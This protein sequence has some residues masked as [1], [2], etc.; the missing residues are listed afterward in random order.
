MIRLSMRKNGQ[1]IVVLGLEP[2]NL[3]RMQL[4]EPVRVNLRHL[5][6]G[7]KP[8]D[9]PDIDVMVAATDT[10][11]WRGFINDLGVTDI[12]RLPPTKK[13][14]RIPGCGCTGEVHP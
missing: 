2:E 10:D 1:R 4:G 13:L 14:C 3:R 7:E 8:T 5:V 11:D 12:V 6:P 9:L